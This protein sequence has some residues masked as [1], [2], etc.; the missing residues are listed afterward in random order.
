MR[1][2]LV[3]CFIVDLTEGMA[4]GLDALLLQVHLESPD[5]VARHSHGT[6]L[7]DAAQCHNSRQAFPLQ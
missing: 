6:Y 3:M 5:G 2:L 1:A 4:F 7:T